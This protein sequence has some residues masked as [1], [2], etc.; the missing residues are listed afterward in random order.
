MMT[1]T[2]DNDES[3]PEDIIRSFKIVKKCHEIINNVIY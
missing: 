3:F 2:S 1:D